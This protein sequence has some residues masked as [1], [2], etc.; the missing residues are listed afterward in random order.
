M[1]ENVNNGKNEIPLLCFNF[2]MKAE[3]D[4]GVD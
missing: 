2:K 1:T 4:I 3:E